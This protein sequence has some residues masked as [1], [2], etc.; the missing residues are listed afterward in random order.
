[1]HNDTFSQGY[2]MSFDWESAF[3]VNTAVAK[4]V[5]AEKDRA[6]SIVNQARCA[7]EQWLEPLVSSIS[8][9]A[10]SLLDAGENDEAI[11]QLTTLAVMSTEEATK[12]WT[13]N[14]IILMSQ[15]THHR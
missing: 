7:F 12:R 14:L 3:W 8:E 15:Y 10:K 2:M 1:M 5:Y 13:G 11:D 4:L 9:K 6:V